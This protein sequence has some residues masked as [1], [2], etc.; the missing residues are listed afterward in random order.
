[1]RVVFLNLQMKGVLTAILHRGLRNCFFSF[2]FIYFP[3]IFFSI[4]YFI[5]S[6]SHFGFPP[7]FFCCQT[8]SGCQEEGLIL[9]DKEDRR[10]GFES[11]NSK[12]DINRPTWKLIWHQN[13]PR[14]R[15]IQLGELFY[16]WELCF[17]K[18]FLLCSFMPSYHI[19]FINISWKLGTEKEYVS[20]KQLQVFF[21]FAT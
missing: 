15:S 12:S 11:W 7:N 1:M 9:E 19:F 16:E 21:S 8:K 17:Q 14:D 2:P 6:R 3:Y 18:I 5:L 10:I 13:L 20:S 4:L